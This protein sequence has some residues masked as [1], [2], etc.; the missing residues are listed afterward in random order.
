MSLKF[1]QQPTT[2]PAH[3]HA[4]FTITPVTE[5]HQEKTENQ[6]HKKSTLCTLPTKPDSATIK[7]GETMAQRLEVSLPSY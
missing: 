2:P 5:V 7:Q 4:H 1:A 3:I 6:Y